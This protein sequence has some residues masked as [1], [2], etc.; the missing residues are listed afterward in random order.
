MANFS[1]AVGIQGS[2][3]R[4]FYPLFA[5]KLLIP[6]DKLMRKSKIL[7]ID[8]EPGLLRL[9]TLMLNFRDR[10]EVRSV[11]DATKALSAVVEF[12]PDLVLLDWIM[13]KMNGG[14]VAQQIRADSRVCAT[15]IL[16][17]SA[18]IMKRD[19]PGELA[20]YPAVAKPIGLQEL[21]EAI[22]EQL[23]KAA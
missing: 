11:A 15:R 4:A 7:L 10:Y 2:A 22:E 5:V 23:L 13:P 19:N 17:L 8:D 1:F 16:F 21:V 14:E 6:D 12:K 9:M 20:G 18:I 3:S